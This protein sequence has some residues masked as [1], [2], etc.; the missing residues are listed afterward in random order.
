MKYSTEIFDKNFLRKYS[1]I[2]FNNSVLNRM[3]NTKHLKLTI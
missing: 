2:N 3:F 1:Q